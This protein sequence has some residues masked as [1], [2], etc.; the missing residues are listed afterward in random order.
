MMQ[1]SEAS[2]SCWQRAS[3]IR[4][5]SLNI[6]LETAELAV[7]AKREQ[8]S[9]LWNNVTWYISKWNPHLPAGRVAGLYFSVI[10][11]LNLTLICIYILALRFTVVLIYREGDVEDKDEEL[12]SEA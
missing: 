10:H 2:G 7:I 5:V 1:S 8:T 11:F 3:T 6:R 12:K 9:K 4:P